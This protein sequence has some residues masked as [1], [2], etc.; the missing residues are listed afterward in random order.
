MLDDHG[1]PVAGKLSGTDEDRGAVELQAAALR[2]I[3]LSDPD[4]NV[5]RFITSI[6][7][8]DIVSTAAGDRG[9]HYL[10]VLS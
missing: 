2:H 5:P 8:E 6:D 7:G 4:L 3:A 10:G 1:A 9:C